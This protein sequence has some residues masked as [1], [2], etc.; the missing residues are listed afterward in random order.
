MTIQ[1]IKAA[2]MER[3]TL[4]QGKLRVDDGGKWVLLSEVERHIK[5]LEAIVK[6]LEELRREDGASVLIP[7]DNAD[8]D[9]P[10]SGVEVCD[11]WTDWE[12][13]PFTGD[14]LA[15]ALKAAVEAKRTREAEAT[16]GS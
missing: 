15:E 13:C 10:A 3:Y 8:V 16:K 1:K 11:D 5:E 7:C 14:N 9:G 4:R 6:P 12:P 2:T